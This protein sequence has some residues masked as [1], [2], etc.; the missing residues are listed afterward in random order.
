MLWESVSGLAES[1]HN[2]L[3]SPLEDPKI[4]WPSSINHDHH[5]KLKALSKWASLCWHLEWPMCPNEK[6]KFKMSVMT[7]L[8]NQPDGPGNTLSVTWH[9]ISPSVTQD[10]QSIF[11][12]TCCITSYLMTSVIS[13]P[14]L[15]KHWSSWSVWQQHKIWS[16]KRFSVCISHE[17]Q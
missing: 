16:T 11:V 2:I 1:H 3:S 15:Q 6:V 17:H 14:T 13:H 5:I 7:K 10:T 8:Q 12:N 9:R 4:M